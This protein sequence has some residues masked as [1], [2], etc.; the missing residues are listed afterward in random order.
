[1]IQARDST[2]HHQIAPQ[3]RE[4]PHLEA[5]VT[6]ASDF[7]SRSFENQKP[8]K[9]WIPALSGRA[10]FASLVAKGRAWKCNLDNWQ[11]DTSPYGANTDWAVNGY[12]QGPAKAGTSAEQKAKGVVGQILEGLG[13]SNKPDD[14]ECFM[15][16]NDV[17]ASGY[18]YVGRSSSQ[19]HRKHPN[20]TVV[21]DISHA[22]DNLLPVP[23][24]LP[25]QRR[26][27]LRRGRQ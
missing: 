20:K 9:N 16:I 3:R 10:D 2:Q 6:S 18:S 15:V 24:M 26:N 13:V 8:W 21:A 27:H 23:A 17:I 4:V 14:Y 7:A 5:R 19:F 11:H 25:L 12:S 22:P 1:L